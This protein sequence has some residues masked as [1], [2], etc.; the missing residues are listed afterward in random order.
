[1]IINQNSALIMDFALSVNDNNGKI[2]HSIINCGFSV[3]N[4]KELFFGH[5]GQSVIED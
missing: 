2:G 4:R 1:M 5:F 3:K